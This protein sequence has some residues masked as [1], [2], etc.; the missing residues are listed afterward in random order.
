[1]RV[2]SWSELPSR[3][4]ARQSGDDLVRG[5]GDGSGWCRFASAKAAVTAW[6]AWR[7]ADDARRLANR[8]SG[9]LS[10]TPALRDI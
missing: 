3:G 5:K 7:D 9:M 4:G 6:L 1:M 10:P 2:S 8:C